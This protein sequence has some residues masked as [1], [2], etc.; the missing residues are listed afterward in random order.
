MADQTTPTVGKLLNGTEGR[1]AIHFALA[2]VHCLTDLPPNTEV[3]VEEGWARRC[4]PGEKSV[5]RTDPWLP[6]GCPAGSRCWVFL[7]PGT[8]T[9]LRHVW[10][11]PAFEIKVPTYTAPKGG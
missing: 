7:H 3:M 1:D 6:Q 11:H 10:T 5:G 9:T 2:P 8:I 4:R